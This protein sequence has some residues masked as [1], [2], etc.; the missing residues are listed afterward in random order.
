M[1]QVGGRAVLSIPVS[2]MYLCFYF[3]FSVPNDA[4]PLPTYLST[5][6]FSPYLPAYLPTDLTS[7]LPTLLY[8]LVFFFRVGKR[9]CR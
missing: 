7:Y 8:M 3:Q 6:L 1:M 9:V 2:N 4:S 5:Y